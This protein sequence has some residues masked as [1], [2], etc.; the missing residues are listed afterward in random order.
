MIQGKNYIMTT[1]TNLKANLDNNINEDKTYFLPVYL[2]DLHKETKL[3][4]D[5]ILALKLSF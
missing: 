3:L 1:V 5:S 2:Y 4:K